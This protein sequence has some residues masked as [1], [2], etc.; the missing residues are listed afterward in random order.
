MHYS[1]PAVV[2]V[3]SMLEQSR[4]ASSVRT[5]EPV[6]PRSN[7]NIRPP[8]PVGLVVS[9]PRVG[10]RPRSSR[11]WVGVTANAGGSAAGAGL[12]LSSGTSLSSMAAQ[13]PR[14]SGLFREQCLN[15]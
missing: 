4:V 5:L 9:V 15:L 13:Q 14:S 10:T 12:L 8:E 11:R 2:V 1:P 6:P 7:F 3:A